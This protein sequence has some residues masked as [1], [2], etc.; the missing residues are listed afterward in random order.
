MEKKRKGL[1]SGINKEGVNIK[2]EVGVDVGGKDYSTKYPPIIHALAD[3]V[4]R[5]KL[6]KIYLSL[7]E[8]R[9]EKNV[10]LGCGKHS[11]PFDMVGEYLDATEKG[12]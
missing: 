8:F 3:P 5:E 2:Y 4:K 1:T 9:Q 7:K 11:M 10:Y 12:V 6:E